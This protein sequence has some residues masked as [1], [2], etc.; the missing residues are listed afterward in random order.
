MNLIEKILR[1]DDLSVDEKNG[2][3]NDF[4]SIE[5]N[6]DAVNVTELL[7][8]YDSWDSTPQGMIYWKELDKLVNQLDMSFTEKIIADC[9]SS[10][11]FSSLEIEGIKLD[12]SLICDDPR[13]RDMYLYDDYIYRKLS[14]VFRWSTTPQG[15]MYWEQLDTIIRENT[16]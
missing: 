14:T 6:E 12:L 15:I 11:K 13:K 10:G 16:Y 3:L 5:I 8:F 7:C 9:I 1:Y 2:I 4:N